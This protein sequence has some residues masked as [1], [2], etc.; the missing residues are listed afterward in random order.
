[1]ALDNV[2]VPSRIEAGVLPR[3]LPD[4]AGIA[5]PFVSGYAQVFSGQ[6]GVLL[7][8]VTGPA[9]PSWPIDATMIPIPGL[10]EGDH[11]VCSD[12]ASIEEGGPK[13]P[14]NTIS[15]STEQVDPQTPGARL[16]TSD[17]SA[18]PGLY[19]GTIRHGQQVT[20]VQLYLSR[21]RDP[22]NGD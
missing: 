10:A 12:L 3:R 8:T 14:A 22:N 17:T 6:G 20:P 7:F 18:P 21:A 1:M 15:V 5:F 9:A 11:L 16:T 19:V 4:A 13:I 2:T